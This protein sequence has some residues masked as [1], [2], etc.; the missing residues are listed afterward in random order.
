[1]FLDSICVANSSGDSGRDRC[2]IRMDAS[3]LSPASASISISCQTP[4]SSLSVRLRGTPVS[5]VSSD[6]SKFTNEASSNLIF[7]I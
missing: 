6:F 5:P 2:R 3:T 7:T 1:M 4:L